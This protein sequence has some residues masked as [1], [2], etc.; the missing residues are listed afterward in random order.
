MRS[1]ACEGPA[2]RAIQRSGA[3]TLAATEL[4]TLPEPLEAR[5]DVAHVWTDVPPRLDEL[6]GSRGG[7]DDL[8]LLQAL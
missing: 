5:G 4:A 8:V 6:G 7:S 3:E 1:R 2:A